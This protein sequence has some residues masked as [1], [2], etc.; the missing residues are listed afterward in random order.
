MIR[1]DTPNGMYGSEGD[2]FL[3][4][5]CLKEGMFFTGA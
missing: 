5:F 4:D 1:G 2:G 3:A